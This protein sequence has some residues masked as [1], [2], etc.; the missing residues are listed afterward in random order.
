MVTV[1]KYNKKQL[2]G[3][4]GRFLEVGLQMSKCAY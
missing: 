3:D 1:T 4:F 2:K